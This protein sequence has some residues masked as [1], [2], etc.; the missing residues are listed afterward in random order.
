MSG[1]GRDD[2][3]AG[4]RR[5][6]ALDD[7]GAGEVEGPGGGD[8]GVEGGGVGDLADAGG[9]EEGVVAGF[10]GE[11]GGWALDEGGVGEREAG[12]DV[13]DG[14]D[15][16]GGDDVGEGEEFGGVGDGEVVLAGGEGGFIEVGENILGCL[17][18]DD[19]LGLDFRDDV[20]G[21]VEVA[22]FV[23]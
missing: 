2:G 23:P 4:L 3:E 7:E 8:A 9:A 19:F 20:D 13:D 10:D 14:A 15:A 21:K 17:H 18:V 16:D 12:G 1:Q 11:D 6:G 5:A 22:T